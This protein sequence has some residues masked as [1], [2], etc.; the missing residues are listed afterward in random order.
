MNRFQG[1]GV[2]GLRSEDKP[3]SPNHVHTVSTRN[4]V[5]LT[6]KQEDEEYIELTEAGLMAL[7]ALI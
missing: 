1:L 2:E 7:V 3:R 4:L 5:F 6:W